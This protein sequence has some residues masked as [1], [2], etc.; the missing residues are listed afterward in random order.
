MLPT[1]AHRKK[2]AKNSS[3]CWCCFF[4]GNLFCSDRRFHKLRKTKGN[5]LFHLFI[6]FV[7]VKVLYPKKETIKVAVSKNTLR[8]SWEKRRKILYQQEL[9]LVCSFFLINAFCFFLVDL[10]VPWVWE[11]HI[12]LEKTEALTFKFQPN[13]CLLL[14]QFNF[15]LLWFNAFIRWINSH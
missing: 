4:C 2:K 13:L 3:S 15:S 10:R 6:T 8:K 11:L 12:S 1:C 14:L 5:W 9:K 7:F